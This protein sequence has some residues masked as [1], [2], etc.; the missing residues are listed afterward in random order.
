MPALTP[1]V[2]AGFVRVTPMSPSPTAIRPAFPAIQCRFFNHQGTTGPRHVPTARNADRA[3]PVAL[4]WLPAVIQTFVAP[5]VKLRVVSPDSSLV[6]PSRTGG[7]LLRNASVRV[8]C[9]AGVASTVHGSAAPRRA[10]RPF[11]GRS[12]P[13]GTGRVER[14]RTVR[15]G[16]VALAVGGV[17]SN[18]DMS[19]NE[20]V[21]GAEGG[22]EG[23]G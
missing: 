5:T 10:Q 12:T 3:V 21:G 20:P 14:D 7:L 23:E 9:P 15:E 13:R 6:F 22:C 1:P 16:R 2:D 4:T 11:S 19:M 8:L 18:P 17:F